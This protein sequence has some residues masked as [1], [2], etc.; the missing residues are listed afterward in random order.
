M[1]TF[2]TYLEQAGRSVAQMFENFKGFK[3]HIA[4]ETDDS[5]NKFA[6]VLC[7]EGMVT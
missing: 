2:N 7:R 5:R 1:P 6:M 4:C 3:K